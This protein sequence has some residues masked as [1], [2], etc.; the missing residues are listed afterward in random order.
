MNAKSGANSL[1]AC[2]GRGCGRPD[3]KGRGCARLRAAYIVTR[4]AQLPRELVFLRERSDGGRIPAVT[5]GRS[6]A[7]PDPPGRRYRAQGRP[8]R[9]PDRLLLRTR[10]ASG[11]QGC[12]RAGAAHPAG[13]PAPSFHP[14]VRRTSPRWGASRAWK[15]GS[16]ASCARACPGHTHSCCRPRARPRAACSTRSAAPSACAS[17]PTRYRACCWRSCRSRS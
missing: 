7:T 6:A 5:P 12:A 9:L 3:E 4:G 14:G 17:R 2:M 15:P 10:V 8:H 13:R 1:T 16:S 11:G